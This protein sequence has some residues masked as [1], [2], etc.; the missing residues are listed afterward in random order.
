MLTFGGRHTLI[1]HVLQSLP[2]Y[3]MYSINPPKGVINQIHKIM[4]RFFW[5]STGA[6]KVKHWVAWETLC[7]PIKEGKLDFR[8]LHH[9]GEVL[10]AKF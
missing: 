3:L 8:S 1:K 2:I 7:L 6:L 9:V 10:F 5:G 4:I